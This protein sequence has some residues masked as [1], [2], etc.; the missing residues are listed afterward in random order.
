MS[1]CR[2]GIRPY[3]VKEYDHDEPIR[4]E[5]VMRD[6]ER[7]PWTLSKKTKDGR[8]REFDHEEVDGKRYLPVHEHD[9]DSE[10]NG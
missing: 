4:G 10:V 6:G 2:W 7:V 3:P 8:V 5:H 9:Y 1:D